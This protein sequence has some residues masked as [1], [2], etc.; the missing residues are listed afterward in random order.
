[1]ALTRKRRLENACISALNASTNALNRYGAEAVQLGG[2]EEAVRPSAAPI[3][4]ANHYGDLQ[5]KV[6]VACL[7]RVWVFTNVDAELFQFT[8]AHSFKFIKPYMSFTG[9]WG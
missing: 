4:G 8:I 9:I 7:P 3:N 6:S 1:M 5:S 2:D